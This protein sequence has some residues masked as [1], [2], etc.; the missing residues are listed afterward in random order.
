MFTWASVGL[1]VQERG[2][3]NLPENWCVLLGRKMNLLLSSGDSLLSRGNIVTITF[4]DAALEWRFELLFFVVLF[5]R[6]LRRKVT[7]F[8]Y[9]SEQGVLIINFDLHYYKRDG[10]IWIPVM[11]YPI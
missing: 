5:C 3:A 8:L 10:Q 6:A 2:A 7:R 1:V 9:D 11:L 4:A